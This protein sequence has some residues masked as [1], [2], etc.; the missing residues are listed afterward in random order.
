MKVLVT[1]IG[2]VSPLGLGRREVWEAV[3]AGRKLAP[4]ASTRFS[5]E[6]LGI[7]GV[8]EVPDLDMDRILSGVDTRRMPRVSQFAC[9]AAALALKDAGLCES[10]QGRTVGIDP[11]IGER[12]MLCVA[13]THGSAEHAV[14]F[15]DEMIDYGSGKTSAMLFATS[16]YNAPISAIAQSLR[17]K[18][19]CHAIAGGCEAGIDVVGL[20]AEFIRAGLADVALVG[21]TEELSGV[22]LSAYR[23]FGALGGPVPAEGACF[24]VLEAESAAKAR[25]AVSFCE[26]TSYETGMCPHG[27]TRQVCGNG[28]SRE[29]EER[30]SKCRMN[31]APFVGRAFAMSSA[32]DVAFSSMCLSER[33]VPEALVGKGG[34]HAIRQGGADVFIARSDATIVGISWTRRWNVLGLSTT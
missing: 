26:L 2:I 9:A 11:V 13:S 32:A 12:L 15:H 6:G 33:E 5:I 20:G 28:G 24:L 27:M 8:A 1:G 31:S 14:K 23:R 34:T 7:P 22:F 17:V 16:T 19:P 30:K 25:R 4:A 29:K 18:G 3:K 10:A 21:G